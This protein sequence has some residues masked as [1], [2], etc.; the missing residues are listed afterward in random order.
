VT[1]VPPRRER[2]LE[3]Q[4]LAGDTSPGGPGKL[5]DDASR[6]PPHDSAKH[7]TGGP[8]AISVLA[9]RRNQPTVGTAP[10]APP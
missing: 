10:L 9:S 6:T 5:N 8:G 7:G 4:P 2:G 3:A 1:L